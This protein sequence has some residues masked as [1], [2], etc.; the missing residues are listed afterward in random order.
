MTINGGGWTLILCK[1]SPNPVWSN[2]EAILRNEN[3]PSINS[4][5]S[6]IGYADYI[7]KSSSSFQCR[8][9]ANTRGN[10]GGIWT[11]N[12]PCSFVGTMNA[13]T[14]ITLV[15]KFGSW[16][17]NDDG[18]EERMPWYA[19]GSEASLQQVIA[20]TVTG[21]EHLLQ[22]VAGILLHGLVAAECHIR[23]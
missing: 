7:K 10:H 1:K 3:S 15:T 5:Y 23:G 8:I 20:P 18:I 17:Y 21:G 13:S 4:N 9:D 22:I 14:N 11:A 16:N 19:P 6:I 12:Q 2:T